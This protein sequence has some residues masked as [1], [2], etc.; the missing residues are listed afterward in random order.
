MTSLQT[1]DSGARDASPGPDAERIPKTAARRG[2]SSA[3]APWLRWAKVAAFVAALAPAIRLVIL[4]ATDGLGANPVEFITRST[5]TWALVMLCITLALTPA[6]LLTHWP[7]WLRFRRMLGLF[8]FFYASVHFATYVWLDQWFDW[9]GIVRDVT[10][11]RPFITV[12]FLSLLLMV[13]LAITS[14]KAV[15]KWLGGRR[16]QRLHRAVYAVAV[17]AILHFWWMKAGKNDWFEPLIYGSVVAVLLG[18]RVV[19]AVMNRA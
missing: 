1:P 15:L 2:A 13:P 6:R 5:G 9:Q 14:P 18:V 7:G 10:G 12:G 19:R 8:A 11:K 17:L 16:W 3:S 4:G